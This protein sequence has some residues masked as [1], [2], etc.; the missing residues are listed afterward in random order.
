M[1]PLNHKWT[2]SSL[3]PPIFYVTKNLAIKRQK[4]PHWN[5][6]KLWLD[7][8]PDHGIFWA[9]YFTLHR[10]FSIFCKFVGK[11]E[12]I[13]NINF[14]LCVLT[15]RFCDRVSANWDICHFSRFKPNSIFLKTHFMLKEKPFFQ[16]RWI[17]ILF[18]L[19]FPTLLQLFLFITWMCI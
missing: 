9:I 4:V 19:M 15:F 17:E 8:K 3:A 18:W 7:D 1:L 2:T 5:L 13:W 6:I 16:I 10:W 12:E 14:K 11:I